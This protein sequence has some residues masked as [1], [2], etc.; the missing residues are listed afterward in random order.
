M[1]REKKILKK[2][3]FLRVIY[4]FMEEIKQRI[5]EINERVGEISNIFNIYG[6]TDKE[7][8]ESIKLEINSFRD[9]LK[10]ITDEKL[11]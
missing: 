4:K 3:Y 9:E 7:L 5:R 11:K 2:E 10:N 8:V 6:I 1:K